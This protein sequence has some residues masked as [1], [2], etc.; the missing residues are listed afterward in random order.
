MT[1]A[2]SPPTSIPISRVGEHA[3]TFSGERSSSPLKSSSRTMRSSPVILG[4]VLGG[5]ESLDTR[6]VEDP[7]RVA[8]LLDF[9]LGPRPHRSSTRGTGCVE[10]RPRQANVA[11]AATATV[12]AFE[13]DE[14]NGVGIEL[15]ELARFPPSVKLCARQK[16]RMHELKPRLQVGIRGW[17]PPN[18][19]RRCLNFCTLLGPRPPPPC[20]RQKLLSVTPSSMLAESTQVV[21]VFPAASHAKPCGAFTRRSQSA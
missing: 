14:S 21:G 6:A 11:D 17:T 16:Q 7:A 4:G 12:V 10:R 9:L 2:S 20:L 13:Q 3:R 15:K 1:T 18:R 5:D 19:E 8:V